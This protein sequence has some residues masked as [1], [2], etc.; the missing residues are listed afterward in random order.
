MLKSAFMSEIQCF[1][2]VSWKK[3]MVTAHSLCGFQQP[4]LIHVH[5]CTF[6]CGRNLLKKTNPIT[7]FQSLHQFW[8]KKMGKRNKQAEN[9]ILF[10][11]ISV[12][13]KPEA[14]LM[15]WYSVALLFHVSLKG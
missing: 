10:T 4:L 2:P 15:Q 9:L 5:V 8:K 1:L 13:M 7:F 6:P 3:C 14:C 11:K 12:Y